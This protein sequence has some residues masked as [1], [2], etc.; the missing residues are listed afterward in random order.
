MQPPGIRFRAAVKPKELARLV[1]SSI[2]SL[3]KKMHAGRR[4]D[5]RLNLLRLRKAGS[6]KTPEMIWVPTGEQKYWEP[7]VVKFAGSS[8]KVPDVEVRIRGGKLHSLC[9]EE[10]DE[11]TMG[12]TLCKVR[13]GVD[14]GLAVPGSPRRYLVP[15]EGVLPCQVGPLIGEVLETLV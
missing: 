7:R 14:P 4:R 13:L 12:E 8:T 9:V 5:H 11:S 15:R 6:W 1:H 3:R 10:L 2:R